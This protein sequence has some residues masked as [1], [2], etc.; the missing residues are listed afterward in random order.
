MFS[1]EWPFSL[2]ISVFSQSAKHL[3]ALMVSTVLVRWNADEVQ[4]CQNQLIDLQ[5]VKLVLQHMETVRLGCLD[6]HVTI[7][8]QLKCAVYAIT[9][10]GKD[11]SK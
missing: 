2:V 3:N 8:M 5:S 1:F 4:Y 10:I 6:T 7:K 11:F 9:F